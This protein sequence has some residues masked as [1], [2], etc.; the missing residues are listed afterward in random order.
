[1]NVLFLALAAG[2]RLAVLDES[3]EV[4]NDGGRAVILTDTLRPW[5]GYQLA[6]GVELVPLGA[7]SKDRLPMR[8]VNL[9]VVRIPDKL[10]RIVGKGP[11]RQPSKRVRRAYKRRI[12]QPLQRR[13]IGLQNRYG[14][15]VR[16]QDLVMSMLHQRDFDA[17]IV[18]NSQSILLGGQVLRALKTEANR[19]PIVRFSIDH[20][21][22]APAST[23]IASG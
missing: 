14:R 21:V 20:I 11:L 13:A 4:V 2:R 6:P 12:G 3:A 7:L 8:I 23:P 22:D 10:L 15:P 19:H 5:H 16:H 17:I 1:M 18:A 9:V